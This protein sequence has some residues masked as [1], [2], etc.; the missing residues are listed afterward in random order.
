M[1]PSMQMQEITIKRS[2]E[3]HKKYENQENDIQAILNQYESH[4]NQANN[5]FYSKTLNGF[6]LKPISENSANAYIMN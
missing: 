1:E 2:D 4:E 5:T 3:M 6:D